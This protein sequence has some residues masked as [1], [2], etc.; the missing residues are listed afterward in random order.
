MAG[1]TADYEETAMTIAV[2]DALQKRIKD[3]LSE[4]LVKMAKEMIDAAVDDA[5]KSLNIDLKSYYSYMTREKMIDVLVT[6]NKNG[7]RL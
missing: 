3:E 7:P 4:P 5:I 6:R 2:G 1:Y